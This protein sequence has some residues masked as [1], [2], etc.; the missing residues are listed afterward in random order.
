[1][2]GHASLPP[3]EVPVDSMARTV[4]RIIDIE[5]PI[6]AEE[7]VTRVRDLW[8]LARAGARIQGAV[9]E[10][11]RHPSLGERLLVDGGFHDIAGRPVTVRDRAKAASR[12]LRKPELLPPREIR[13][14]IV[15]IVREVHGARSE[16]L[17]P[18]VARTLGFQTTSQ[19]LRDRIVPQIDA[20]VADGTLVAQ[21]DRLALPAGA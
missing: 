15:D 14:A 9:E 18:A 4:E 10:A 1:M 5:G 13:Q 2:P 19:P 6:H 12:T 8:G 11:L 3:H 21:G 20:L 7:I 16:E 17:V